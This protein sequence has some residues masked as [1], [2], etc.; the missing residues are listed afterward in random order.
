VPERFLADAVGSYYSQTSDHDS[1]TTIH[2]G[3]N[4]VIHLIVTVTLRAL[5]RDTAAATN[6]TVNMTIPC[7]FEV[8]RA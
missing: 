2:L 4:P 7:H 6:S 5:R 3:R 1:T 8:Q